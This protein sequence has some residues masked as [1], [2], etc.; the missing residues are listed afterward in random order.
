MSDD[1]GSDY[2][3]DKSTDASTLESD[4]SNVFIEEIN[5]EFYLSVKPR[6]TIIRAQI[7]NGKNKEN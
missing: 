4:S 6:R 5:E 2:F 7:F 3:S 1:F